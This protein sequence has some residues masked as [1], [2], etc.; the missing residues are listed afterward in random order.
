MDPNA[1]WN[2]ILEALTEEDWE[3]ATYAT[4]DLV[5]WLEAQG[6]VPGALIDVTKTEEQ[7]HTGALH[8][9]RAIREYTLRRHEEDS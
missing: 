2:L 6:F 3:A 9:V 5:Q 8:V 4:D 7:A 1:T